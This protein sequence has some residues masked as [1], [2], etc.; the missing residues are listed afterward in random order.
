LASSPN[1]IAAKGDFEMNDAP[2]KSAAANLGATIHGRGPE[3]VLVMHDWMGDHSIYDAI[4]PYLDGATFTYAFVDLR[5]YGKSKDLTGDYT[6]E[7][8]AKDCLGVADRLGWQR[9]HLIGHSMTGMATQRI[10]ADAPSR[11]KCA[12][13]VCPISAAGNGLDEA[14]LKFFANT[15]HDDVAFRRLMKFISGGLSEQWAEVKL[16]Q[17]RRTVAPA[18]RAGYL[19]MLTTTDF[20]DEVRGLATP[21]LVVLGEK[22]PGL[23]EAAM[24]KSFLAWHPN[25]VFSTMPNC[26]HY[27]MQEC[28]PYFATI[29]E[30][31][32]RK[33][34][35]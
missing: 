33:H 1:E 30:A 18:C 4:V 10:A 28:P 17:N 19:R 31:F 3:G 24:K 8:I 20:V 25:A 5:G 12:V 2:N 7:E 34:A 35:G 32:L 23:D 13:A 21:Y 9:F 16:R 15:T 11:I 6:V 14:S 26:G 27:P 22:D 29:V